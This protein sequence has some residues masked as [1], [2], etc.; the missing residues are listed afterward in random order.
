[1]KNILKNKWHLH[2]G[3]GS[4]TMAILL[5][6]F[7]FSDSMGFYGSS[8]VSILLLF[9]G[10]VFWEIRQMSKLQEDEQQSYETSRDDVIAGV[11]GGLFCFIIAIFIQ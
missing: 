7:T 11:L 1:M 4:V 8:L 2:F 5:W 6:L 3:I 9:I 10:C